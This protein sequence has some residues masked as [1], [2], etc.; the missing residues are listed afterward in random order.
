V[1]NMGTDRERELGKI[2]V[3]TLNRGDTFTV[4]TPGG[5][6]YGDPF[7]RDPDV[8]ASDVEVGTV[9]REAALADY[10]VA[11]TETGAVDEARTRELRSRQ[12]PEPGAIGFDPVR[13][14]WDS[15]FVDEGVTRLNELLVAEPAHSRNELRR[16]FY[17]A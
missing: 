4:M 11:L 3:V 7:A 14:A 17:D 5:G 8:V 1:M 16:R 13:L 6:G 10:G 9:T 12:R 2:D 15:V